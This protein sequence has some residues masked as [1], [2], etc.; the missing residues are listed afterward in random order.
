MEEK[1]DGAVRHSMTPEEAQVAGV[2]V[3]VEIAEKKLRALK[4][5]RVGYDLLKDGLTGGF[6]SKLHAGAINSLYAGLTGV[7]D[8][9]IQEQEITVK[10]LRMTLVHMQEAAAAAGSR[11]VRP[12]F[13]G[14][15]N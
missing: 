15:A 3:A 1:V 12:Q 8:A 7:V 2:M 5:Q 11:I 6:L 10:A 9:N 4:L 14:S 13:Q